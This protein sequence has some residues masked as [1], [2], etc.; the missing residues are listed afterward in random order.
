MCTCLYRCY[1][2]MS[3]EFP[4]TR[5]LYNFI[6]TIY[7][8]WC[9]FYCRSRL[10]SSRCLFLC[11][12]FSR[13]CTAS[14]KICYHIILSNSAVFSCTCNCIKLCLSNTFF[15]SHVTHQWRVKTVSRTYRSSYGIFCSSYSLSDCSNCNLFFF[16][17]FLSWCWGSVTASFTTGLYNSNS[18]PYLNNII[19]LKQFFY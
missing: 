1:H 11:S 5:H 9:S 19:Y 15:L 7:T 2:V 10:S 17:F 8:Y 13:S 4:H 6:S 3:Y 14:R 18:L 12:W 16:S